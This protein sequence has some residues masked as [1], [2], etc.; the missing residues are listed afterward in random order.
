MY[1]YTLSTIIGFIA[2]AF[3]ITSYFLKNKSLFLIA[4]AGAILFLAV[5]C[6]FIEQYY[7]MI[8]YA[9]GLLRVFTFYMYEKANKNPPYYIILMFIALFVIFYVLVN[10]VILKTFKP[11]DII[12]MV[13]NVMYTYAFSIRNLTL[14]RHIFAI[15][16]VLSI[17][18][19][20]LINGTAFV[21]ISYSFELCANLTATIYNS[22]WFKDILNRRKNKQN[23]T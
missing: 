2:M 11:I 13:A 4:Q 17:I 12:L 10:V 3:A 5:S 22:K 18:Y 8:S 9:I 14:M 15:P 6:L 7:A 20:L 21:I 1:N 16:L 19:Y 23:K